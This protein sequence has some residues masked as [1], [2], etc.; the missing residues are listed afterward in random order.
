MTLFFYDV[1]FN[2]AGKVP[3]SLSARLL[4]QDGTY[5]LANPGQSQLVEAFWIKLT[6]T[7]K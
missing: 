1:I 2:V 7:K 6:A 4:M 3:L 5:L